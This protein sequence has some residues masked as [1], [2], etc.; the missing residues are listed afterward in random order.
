[1]RGIGVLVAGMLAAA[2][3]SSAAPDEAVV[4]VCF[5]YGC[6]QRAPVRFSGFEL[7]AIR[8]ALAG[9]RTP[10]DERAAIPVVLQSMYRYAGRQTPIA[11]DRSGNL[12]DDGVHGRM[13]CIDHTVTTTAFLQLMVA[14]GWL[15]F[16]SVA[17]AATRFEGLF[18]RHQSAVITDSMGESFVVDAWFVDHGQ[19]AIVL[20]LQKWM[21]G[22]GPNVY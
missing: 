3:A 4:E 13:D 1:M 17:E 20:P 10:E 22:G 14:R 18:A 19:L 11:V 5:N 8:D 6:S 9:V 21:N 2:S 16:H 15:R 12:L 7:A